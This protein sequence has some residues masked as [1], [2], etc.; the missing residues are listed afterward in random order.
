MEQLWI[1]GN[2][3]PRFINNKLGPFLESLTSLQHTID[4]IRELPPSPVKILDISSEGVSSEKEKELDEYR[5][6]QTS[7]DEVT[8]A[9]EQVR[10]TIDTLGEE[11]ESPALRLAKLSLINSML[12]RT[13][14]LLSSL[15]EIDVGGGFLSGT[16]IVRQHFAKPPSNR[17]RREV[18]DFESEAADSSDENEIG[19]AHSRRLPRVK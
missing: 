10:D 11:A 6:K 17:V 19:Q 9:L 7:W 18:E 14:A 5:I 15:E 13:Q 1:K 4:E 8:Q 12:A 16:G 3:T 2:L